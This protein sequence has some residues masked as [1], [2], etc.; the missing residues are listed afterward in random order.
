MAD[1]DVSY[2]HLVVSVKRIT[3]SST[4]T[5]TTTTTTTNDVNVYNG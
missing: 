2:G 4:A 1:L 3:V 5:T